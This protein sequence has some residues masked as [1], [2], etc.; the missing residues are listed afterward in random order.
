MKMC[1]EFAFLIIL[2]RHP[3]SH[4]RYPPGPGPRSIPPPR[5]SGDES[6][7]HVSR[8][9]S[10]SHHAQPHNSRSGHSNRNVDPRR[11]YQSTSSGG[12]GGSRPS[13]QGDRSRS[14][15]ATHHGYDDGRGQQQN[16]YTAVLY[17][18]IPDNNAR[19]RGWKASS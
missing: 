1:T 16:S 7:G 11:Q 17:T 8:N 5:G 3:N 14:T 9:A 4:H 15:S 10:R 6:F 13:S 19:I 12:A 18:P 2:Q